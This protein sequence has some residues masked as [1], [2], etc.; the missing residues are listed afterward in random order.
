[1]CQAMTSSTKVENPTNV[2][3][4]ATVFEPR[5]F[6]GIRDEDRSICD[7]LVETAI[8]RDDE[9]DGVVD[10]ACSSAPSDCH[11]VSSIS[12]SKSTF[13]M[14]RPVGESMYKRIFDE[15]LFASN[16]HD[17]DLMIDGFLRYSR[18]DVV[19]VAKHW[20]RQDFFQSLNN[21]SVYQS[22]PPRNDNANLIAPFLASTAA[23]PFG[24]P[25]NIEI[26]GF[27]TDALRGMLK[28]IFTIMPDSIVCQ[29]SG[30]KVIDHHNGVIRS[31][32]QMSLVGTA[33]LH[34]STKDIHGFMPYIASSH[35][36]LQDPETKQPTLAGSLVNG[37]S[38]LLSNVPLSI[39]LDVGL[40]IDGYM[41]YH[42]DATCNKVFRLEFH[43]FRAKTNPFPLS[44][45]QNTGVF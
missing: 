29:R 30:V 42:F 3:A 27:Q 12:S 6:N 44:K 35:P 8:D 39:T 5:S 32:A 43:Y 36:A 22:A 9:G 45:G 37:I 40:E 31:V 19:T 10:Q 41:M 21:T 11:S 15:F 20:N 34:T 7:R 14:L 2:P 17:D 18:P 1:M 24:L 13:P 26:K 23:N 16:G 25:D 33:V 28:N 38:S 4:T